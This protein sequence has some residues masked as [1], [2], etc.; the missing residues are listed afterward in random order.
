[1]DA[2]GAETAGAV[3]AAL[4]LEEAE[5]GDLY[6]IE[7][8][9]YEY[10]DETELQRMT[11]QLDEANLSTAEFRRRRRRILKKGED[12]ARKQAHDEVVEKGEWGDLPP[13][14]HLPG[15]S[16]QSLL[17]EEGG[18]FYYTDDEKTKCEREVFQK[19]KGA[20]HNFLGEK[21]RF[22]RGNLGED[23]ALNLD[24]IGEF[25]KETQ[26]HIKALET[27]IETVSNDADQEIQKLKDHGHEDQVDAVVVRVEQ[28]I[29]AINSSIDEYKRRRDG[30]ME[31]L[32]NKLEGSDTVYDYIFGRGP[33]N[34]FENRRKAAAQSFR[35][36]MKRIIEIREGA[37]RTRSGIASKPGR[38]ESIQ[39]L[40]D[41]LKK[42]IQ[43]LQFVQALEGDRQGDEAVKEH[44]EAFWGRRIR[45]PQLAGTREAREKK[46]L[47]EIVKRNTKAE[48]QF[49]QW[50]DWKR[51]DP[52]S[53]KTDQVRKGW[54]DPPPKFALLRGQIADSLFSSTFLVYAQV[55]N[56]LVLI[57]FKTEMSPWT[58]EHLMTRLKDGYTEF[59]MKSGRWKIEGSY[60]QEPRTRDNLL[61]MTKPDGDRQELPVSL[62]KS[63][64][65]VEHD[66]I[67]VPATGSLKTRIDEYNARLVSAINAFEFPAKGFRAMAVQKRRVFKELEDEWMSATLKVRF[68]G[69][70]DRPKNLIYWVKEVLGDNARPP[71]PGNTEPQP[72]KFE[73]Y[74]LLES[75]AEGAI[76]EVM[77]D[78]WDRRE[79]IAALLISGEAEK[80]A[81]AVVEKEEYMNTLD[82]AFEAMEAAEDEYIGDLKWKKDLLQA[83][84][85][86]TGPLPDAGNLYHTTTKRS[87][88]VW[89]RF[90]DRL[91]NDLLQRKVSASSEK[92]Y[93]DDRMPKDELEL[94]KKALGPLTTVE[95]A[96]R[97]LNL[98]MAEKQGMATTTTAAAGI[99]ED[100]VVQREVVER[101]L[102][103]VVPSYAEGE[104]ESHQMQV[105]ADNAMDIEEEGPGEIVYDDESAQNNSMQ[106]DGV[107]VDVERL[108][109]NEEAA[110]SASRGAEGGSS[111]QG[112]TKKI[113][114]SLAPR[115][116]LGSTDTHGQA[117]VIWRFKRK[118]MNKKDPGYRK[119]SL[120][121]ERR[122][123]MR[124]WPSTYD[125]STFRTVL[126][127][128]Q[129]RK[130]AAWGKSRDT[131]ARQPPDQTLIFQT[132]RNA[133]EEAKDNR[134]TFVNQGKK[135]AG[136]R[137]TEASAAGFPAEA[138]EAAAKS[139]K[140]DA[141]YK[142]QYRELDD[143]V[144][145]TSRRLAEFLAENPKFR[146]A[147]QREGRLMAQMRRARLETDNVKHLEETI[148]KL[149]IELDEKLKLIERVKAA[150]EEGRR[151]EVERKEFTPEGKKERDGKSYKY[152]PVKQRSD[153]TEYQ[154]VWEEL[155]PDQGGGWGEKPTHEED[156]DRR[157][158]EAKKAEYD[159]KKEF[160]NRNTLSVEIG[161]IKDELLRYKGKL[162]ELDK[163]GATLSLMLPQAMQTRGRG[164]AGAPVIPLNRPRPPWLEY[165][166]I[167]SQG[168]KD[169]RYEQKMTKA[170]M[171]AATQKRYEQ[172]V[173]EDRQKTRQER[174]ALRRYRAG[175][176]ERRWLAK[177]QRMTQEKRARAIEAMTIG[178]LTLPKDDALIKKNIYDHFDIEFG[179]ATLLP[180][181]AQM[182]D[183][184]IKSMLVQNE[185][186]Y[187]ISGEKFMEFF[188]RVNDVIQRGVGAATLELMVERM[189]SES[190]ERSE[191]ATLVRTDDPD[192]AQDWIA[193]KQNLSQVSVEEAN[194]D[195]RQH[196]NK[197]F[198]NMGVSHQEVAA[199]DMPR[200]L[201][202][203]DLSKHLARRLWRSTL[204]PKE[205]LSVS[206]DKED[207][208]GTTFGLVRIFSS[209][210]GRTLPKSLE[211]LCDIGVVSTEEKSEDNMYAP[212]TQF[213]KYVLFMKGEN[214]F[215]MYTP[216]EAFRAL[217][218][219]NQMAPGSEWKDDLDKELQGRTRARLEARDAALQA[220]TRYF[221]EY[222]QK[223]GEAAW[224]AEVATER[225]NAMRAITR[226][227]SMV[228]YENSDALERAKQQAADKAVARLEAG[229]RKEG[230]D[231]FIE[232]RNV[233]KYAQELWK[234][235]VLARAKKIPQTALE[236]PWAAGF[237]DLGPAASSGVAYKAVG[238][239]ILADQLA[240]IPGLQ[241]PVMV[242][243]RIKDAVDE[244][245][246]TVATTKAPFPAQAPGP[247]STTQEQ[248]E[249]EKKVAQH[250]A[251]LQMTSKNF[252]EP[253]Y[254]VT[255]QDS[256]LPL[257]QMEKKRMNMINSW[258]Q[259]KILAIMNDLQ[260]GEAVRTLTAQEQKALLTALSEAQKD[261]YRMRYEMG[262]TE[263]RREQALEREKKL[264]G[265]IPNY[266]IIPEA[267][268]SVMAKLYEIAKGDISAQT[269]VRT[270]YDPET[271]RPLAPEIRF[272][273]PQKAQERKRAKARYEAALLEH[274]RSKS[275]LAG[276]EDGTATT[277]TDEN[278]AN[279]AEARAE[280]ERLWNEAKDRRRD[281]EVADGEYQQELDSMIQ[282]LFDQEEKLRENTTYAKRKSLSQ[283]WD[284]KS[285]EA[286]AE[287]AANPDD[288][289]AKKQAKLAAK[290]KAKFADP[291]ATIPLQRDSIHDPIRF[292]TFE[293]KR[294]EC[295]AKIA[296][297][298]EKNMRRK[299]WNE[300]L[301]QNQNVDVDQF[302]MV[303]FDEG[304]REYVEDIVD[305]F[306]TYFDEGVIV[307][308]K[309][310]STQ[311]LREL[312][313]E[314][315]QRQQYKAWEE[316]QQLEELQGRLASGEQLTDDE[317]MFVKG[318]SI[319][320]VPQ[321]TPVDPMQLAMEIEA[322]RRGLEKR[323]GA[324][325][326]QRESLESTSPDPMRRQLSAGQFVK[327]H[328]AEVKAERT[329]LS[330]VLEA[331][332]E[333]K[334]EA[335]VSEAVLA[336]WKHPEH[337]DE[338]LNV[339][340]RVVNRKVHLGKDAYGRPQE[341]WV[342]RVA[343]Q[344]Q[345]IEYDVYKAVGELKTLSYARP[346][347]LPQIAILQASIADLEKQWREYRQ[348]IDWGM[349]FE[350]QPNTFHQ[351]K[352]SFANAIAKFKRQIYFVDV[353]LGN[354]TPYG[355][356]G[357]GGL[358]TKE[359]VLAE[360][361]PAPEE[362]FRLDAM[363][364][365]AVKAQRTKDKPKVSRST[366]HLAE[367]TRAY[368]ALLRN[369]HATQQ[370][371][372][373]AENEKKAAEEGLLKERAGAAMP[374]LQEI[375]MFSSS[376][377]LDR[378]EFHLEK[379][380]KAKTDG[381]GSSQSGQSELEKEIAAQ[382]M[383]IFQMKTRLATYRSA[384]MQQLEVLAAAYSSDGFANRANPSLQPYAKL[385][386]GPAVY[387]EASGDVDM[388]AE[389][390]YSF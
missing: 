304:C 385:R 36:A 3:R 208:I 262:S 264:L 317:L 69:A 57:N 334:H 127:K 98:D 214:L 24:Q 359:Q 372:K 332:K 128:V 88:A 328:E 298:I 83:L 196:F 82:Q 232:E 251:T 354:A 242:A 351:V 382:V 29:D 290:K 271:G 103:Y 268:P 105:D 167:L 116:A 364:R 361:D 85:L 5:P 41:D 124:A 104:E 276:F 197:V 309:D 13:R 6:E 87:N 240:K 58:W 327:D 360:I 147:P 22:L 285:A 45:K 112:V 222:K 7:R 228:P 308:K 256:R 136:R 76:S 193:Y 320:N 120:V 86:G 81:E 56:N 224:N 357:T 8:S 68:K 101:L 179:N 10:D 375:E 203:W 265:S 376:S 311:E 241:H 346:E 173:R 390:E 342:D 50:V 389:T 219:W 177:T 281:Y 23:G 280:T 381:Q 77:P 283:Y 67:L 64:D 75:W 204:D 292:G 210:G 55:L 302:K 340:K 237:L 187:E 184:L 347:D 174:T 239:D 35:D 146:K 371:L 349:P 172:L 115:G 368:S 249:Y 286:A 96:M 370:Q 135:E 301:E 198:E 218:I 59:Y 287:A 66:L 99:S 129:E 114:V 32:K 206:W 270:E 132:R 386:I 191:T 43:T 380:M 296:D 62:I 33:G 11:Q 299:W 143:L 248:E 19:I 119:G 21:G 72:S 60:L 266:V 63:M 388:E 195:W 272:T 335:D 121:A 151:L 155:A 189:V 231:Q 89:P 176:E 73:E 40:I 70:K 80:R 307:L 183:C 48:S 205:A 362:R 321:P 305:S 144:K 325:K 216:E 97:M 163:D 180:G 133:F 365:E 12:V 303:L 110:N 387:N 28:Q 333:L 367:A 273:D 263:E 297:M 343:E 315:T 212:R 267:P 111:S 102:R 92:T 255:A 30:K 207:K 223:M 282:A 313:S 312:A 246:K 1:M 18:E 260:R 293:E 25:Y 95:D 258:L 90:L 94:I 138:V 323:S 122:K 169:K 291:D 202:E 123:P 277:P 34:A 211:F 159:A 275:L 38:G 158:F 244:R 289:Q 330:N 156:F 15:M 316:Q 345:K 234:K 339:T 284:E 84:Y 329:T 310:D 300:W 194:A 200:G 186:K 113:D 221:N 190:M 314:V 257:D 131:N 247:E 161:R 71:K 39:K 108:E 31:E 341:E 259:Q 352:D 16:L 185:S 192:Q 164:R 153:G 252:F 107:D 269:G 230:H 53:K 130:A 42:L 9:A 141:E 238:Y 160:Y 106:V 37:R 215:G 261:V 369:P 165:D 27:Q 49:K 358:P 78:A 274:S 294:A 168:E 17:D 243:R 171:D 378:A 245:I 137:A 162:K 373:D 118:S 319:D 150:Q 74:V 356:P 152:G 134:K 348:V 145:W 227:D 337:L 44:K 170:K 154:E 236:R 149:E 338:P 46:T 366:A 383:L 209:A 61:G 379:L 4:E 229:I 279:L 148:T 233:L 100:V 188:R 350:R 318:F 126:Q 117:K 14:Q 125:R 182:E 336:D 295:R 326:R 20:I 47:K 54:V 26:E 250:Y 226:R 109:A 331:V 139:V 157:R 178:V 65:T 140:E 324:L 374:D 355:T 278:K 199:A 384:L 235:R 213:G 220:E 254:W 253:E 344:V 288:E 175:T 181:G 201:G 91:F 225:A 52:R 51:K 142:R 79:R 2:L 363:V 322:R 377:A 306:N 353:I 217:W 166:Y 93:W